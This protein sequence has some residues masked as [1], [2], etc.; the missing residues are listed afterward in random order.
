M[1]GVESKQKRPDNANGSSS[2]ESG[3]HLDLKMAGASRYSAVVQNALKLFSNLALAGSGLDSLIGCGVY[4]SLQLYFM[5]AVGKAAEQDGRAMDSNCKQG[6]GQK[7]PS[8]TISG[9]RD[10]SP[11]RRRR[12]EWLQGLSLNSSCP[13]FSEL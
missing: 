7:N 3:K 5:R 10:V 1:G 13:G 2:R 8:S 11:V 9:C 6:L 4:L 12:S